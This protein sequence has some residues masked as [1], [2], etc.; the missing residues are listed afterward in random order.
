MLQ[1]LANGQTPPCKQGGK[2]GKQ[3][4]SPWSAPRERKRRSKAVQP[5]AAPAEAVLSSIEELETYTSPPKRHQNGVSSPTARE[6]ALAAQE[7][8]PFRLPDALGA[9]VAAPAAGTAGPLAQGLLAGGDEHFSPLACGLRAPSFTSGL[10]P[11][12]QQAAPPMQQQHQQQQHQQQSAWHVG[13][14]GTAP[15]GS[16]R[17]R[18]QLRHAAAFR[19]AA[20]RHRGASTGATLGA[21]AT[22]AAALLPVVAAAA[23]GS[24][25]TGEAGP[26][27]AAAAAAPSSAAQQPPFV[28]CSQLWQSIALPAAVP[29]PADPLGLQAALPD[30]LEQQPELVPPPAPCAAAAAP[31]HLPPPL[32]QQQQQQQGLAGHS[33]ARCSTGQDMETD[34]RS[35][36]GSERSADVTGWQSLQARLRD[37]AGTGEGA[38]APYDSGGMR[39]GGL[40]GAATAPRQRAGPATEDEPAGSGPCAMARSTADR[41]A[42][43]LRSSLDGPTCSDRQGSLLPLRASVRPHQWGSHLPSPPGGDDASPD[44]LLSGHRGPSSSGN[45][46]QRSGRGS[47]N[48]KWSCFSCASPFSCKQRPAGGGDDSDDEVVRRNDSTDGFVIRRQQSF[49]PPPSPGHERSS[50][51][52]PKRASLNQPP[53]GPAELVHRLDGFSGRCAATTPSAHSGRSPA[54]AP[55]SPASEAGSDDS[56]SVPSGPPGLRSLG[57]SVGL[58]DASIEELA[59]GLAPSE[60]EPSP[61]VDALNDMLKALSLCPTAHPKDA[62]QLVAQACEE[63]A[64]QPNATTARTLE[65][66]WAVHEQLYG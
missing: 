48:G 7:A 50:S 61:T 3:A 29:P 56:F 66:M 15:A 14:A 54:H 47:G 17:Q 58:R 43:S 24:V 9:P 63:H 27:Q 5:G 55:C 35:S 34:L 18:K 4:H 30:C 10:G 31:A 13:S 38:G 6:L 41:E 32:H 65:K 22:A 33:A 19:L 36:W 12:L 52:R 40:A 1:E 21:S 51:G 28:F 53:E 42:G 8:S 25:A 23:G 16:D 11:C 39:L 60:G 37:E 64:I 26:A 57:L 49:P 45:S 62:E 46:R 44:P 2:C 20:A 59:G